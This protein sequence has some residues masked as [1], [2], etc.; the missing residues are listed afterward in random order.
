[1]ATAVLDA[2]GTARSTRVARALLVALG[3]AFLISVAGSDG[4]G[5]AVGRLGGDYPAFHAAG[6]MVLA[7]EGDHLYD[8]RRQADAQAGLYGDEDDG[9]YLPFAYPPAVALA[10]APLAALPYPV[11]YVVQVAAMFVALV[12]ALRLLGPRLA[13]AAVPM[14]VVVAGA[15]TFLPMF[16]S[17]TAG[18]STALALLL[19]VVAWREIEGDRDWLAGIALGLLAYKPQYA[20]VFLFVALVARRWRVLVGAAVGAGAVWVVSALVAGP[21]W[22]GEW[23]SHARRFAEIDTEVDRAN[24]VSWEGMVHLVNGRGT[25]ADLLA[26]VLVVATLGAL[27]WVTRRADQR[28]D[29]A[30]A[31]AVAAPAALLV[32]PHALFYDAG[33]LLLSVGVI[34]TRLG[35]VGRRLVVGL[36]VVAL[37]HFAADLIG[38]TP[39]ALVVL[40]AGAAA[41]AASVARPP[42]VPATGE[43]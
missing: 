12:V 26:G 37:G 42:G 20:A 1:M 8:P 5:A 39:V 32:A 40:A 22:V 15:L 17:V 16:R 36:W 19:V 34:A 21:A 3:I 13:P 24:A 27:A 18:Q 23:W 33:L 30:M 9:G 11:A 25:A 38:M 35:P 43:G 6:E 41:L 28:G 14:V 29:L 4:S 2:P 7:G 31:M 10:Y